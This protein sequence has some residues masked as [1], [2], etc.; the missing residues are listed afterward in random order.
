MDKYNNKQSN[1]YN[2]YEGRKVQISGFIGEY[3]IPLMESSDNFNDETKTPEYISGEAK[4]ARA[5]FCELA[6]EGED[7]DNKWGKN[8]SYPLG[9]RLSAAREFS[10][11][12]RQYLEQ[13]LAYFYRN[14]GRGI[15]TWATHYYDMA[16][17]SF[18]NPEPRMIKVGSGLEKVEGGEIGNVDDYYKIA[19]VCM[20]FAT[21][22]E[23]NPDITPDEDT[24]I[25]LISDYDNYKIHI[26]PLN[27]IVADVDTID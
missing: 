24:P 15:K 9:E 25:A 14:N 1:F 27:A 11:P 7:Y 19:G 23:F 2:T 26:L 20:G 18:D 21:L 22:Q 10:G 3:V 8:S 5:I 17:T 12:M 16:D 6:G 4:K 13:S